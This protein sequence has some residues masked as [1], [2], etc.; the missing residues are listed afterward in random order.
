MGPM[1]NC[2]VGG[3]PLLKGSKHDEIYHVQDLRESNECAT[4]A[5]LGWNMQNT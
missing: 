1:T 4:V 3:S 2:W 5:Q